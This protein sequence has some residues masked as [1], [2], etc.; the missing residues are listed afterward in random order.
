M[1]KFLKLT[2]KKIYSLAILIIG[3]AIPQ[4]INFL[5]QLYY[6][7]TLSQVD[8]QN[9][10]IFWNTSVFVNIIY[11]I[12]YLIWM[13]IIISIIARILKKEK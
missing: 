13:Y 2:K 11:L 5:I 6:S 8:Y 1:L 12:I 4:L 10:L 7:Q 9:F 3:L